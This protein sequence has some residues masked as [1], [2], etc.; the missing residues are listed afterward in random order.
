MS[1][2]LLIYAQSVSLYREK[3]AVRARAG[4]RAGYDVVLLCHV[5]EDVS[6]I[7]SSGVRLIRLSLPKKGY[8][9]TRVLGMARK[10]RR[11]YREEKPDLI[12]HLGYWPILVGAIAARKM[13]S[14]AV[15]NAPSGLTRLISTTNPFGRLYGKTA[16]AVL[17]RALSLRPA[18]T[19]FETAFERD[20]LLARGKLSQKDT[21]LILG[22]GVDVERY[23][24]FK[25]KPSRPVGIIFANNRLSKESVINFVEAARLLKNRG[26]AV[27]CLVMGALAKGKH[28]KLLESQLRVWHEE[29]V[30]AWLGRRSDMAA[31]FAGAHIFAMPL[32]REGLSPYALMALSSGLA[33]VGSDMAG[34]HEVVR[35]E[36]NGLI[37]K[38]N[39]P[40]DLA[41]ALERLVADPAASH[42]YGLRG[43]EMALKEFSMAH[44]LQKTLALW[45]GVIAQGREKATRPKPVP[46]AK[47]LKDEKGAD[48]TEAAQGGG[49]MPNGSEA[50]AQPV[51]SPAPA[52]AAAKAE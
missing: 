5:D 40:D 23:R 18:T 1:R 10:V 32:C 6:D 38:G 31:L 36:E 42:R 14:A 25:D 41:D 21:R 45:D 19:L 22:S 11:I 16:L 33:I 3:C 47:P 7:I 4:L 44:V 12:H 28:T 51:Q 17:A 30:I 2:K 50:V 9:L 26:R 24:P 52:P 29:G 48:N 37:V 49:G 46:V 15:I 8:S 39:K 20:Q 43:R 34:S 27:E 35:H 13:E